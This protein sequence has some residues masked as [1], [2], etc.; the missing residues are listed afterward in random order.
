MVTNGGKRGLSDTFYNPNLPSPPDQTHTAEG[1]LQREKGKI[2]H[3][4]S[5]HTSPSKAPPSVLVD[6]NI[7]LKKRRR[8][9]H[10]T[11]SIDGTGLVYSKDLGGGTKTKKQYEGY[12]R[13]RRPSAPSSY[14][15][16]SRPRA[17]PL[18]VVGLEG[19]KT[20]RSKLASGLEIIHNND[21][22]A[23]TGE[24]AFTTAGIPT[25][26]SVNHGD[27]DDNS[28]VQPLSPRLHN[29]NSVTF[30]PPDMEMDWRVGIVDFNRPPSQMCH[31]PTTTMLSGW[32]GGDVFS[33]SESEGSSDDDDKGME[34]TQTIPTRAS[35]T[36]TRT[37]RSLISEP[38]FVFDDPFDMEM[39]Q[40]M[41][42][43]GAWG[44]STPLNTQVQAREEEERRKKREKKMVIKATSASDLRSK[45]GGLVRTRSLPVMSGVGGRM[46]LNDYD[47]E[48]E[49]EDDSEEQDPY[50]Q[51]REQEQDMDLTTPL[52]TATIDAGLVSTTLGSSEVSQLVDKRGDMTPWILDSLISPPSRYLKSQGEIEQGV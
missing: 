2:H 38:M 11:V 33:S 39:D 27:D 22:L 23:S 34:G 35:R 28:F 26:G 43:D 1:L 7:Q 12:Q 30:A 16:R 10:E 8:A 47:Q 13:E 52:I 36:R 42:G 15:H 50:K 3:A 24:G 32:G 48:N 45:I 6:L 4:Q 44:I 41:F 37:A 17:L 49:G 18:P 5:A 51:E 46:E 9:H 40:N 19:T 25:A 20:R 31:Y 29:K 14:S 21:G